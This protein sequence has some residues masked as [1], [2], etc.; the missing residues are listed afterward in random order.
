MPK[1]ISTDFAS[2]SFEPPP[3]PPPPPPK[4][5][6]F[7]ENIHVKYQQKV[8]HLKVHHKLYV[9]QIKDILVHCHFHFRLAG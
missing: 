2:P 9:E 4:L 7:L 1:D 6:A 8:Y 3:P 5:T